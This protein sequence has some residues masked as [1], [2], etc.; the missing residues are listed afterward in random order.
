MQSGLGDH[1]HCA[2]YRKFP[3]KEREKPLGEDYQ[4]LSPWIRTKVP[5][6]YRVMLEHL[7][8][9]RNRQYVHFTLGRGDELLSVIVTRKLDSE[10]FG[11][12]QLVPA[13]QAAGV[14]VYAATADQFEIAGFET[15]KHLAFVVSNLPRESNLRIAQTLTPDLRAFL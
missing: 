10:S 12:D 11:R 2:H 3:V 1:V 9:Y 13:L 8:K 7:C 5:D 6:G 4:D 14:P 15:D